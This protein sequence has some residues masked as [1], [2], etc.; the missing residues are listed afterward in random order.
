LA[1]AAA[2]LACAALSGCNVSVSS[3]GTPT[4]AKADLEKS[5][6]DKLGTGNNKPKSVTCPNDLEGA[7]G[8]AITCEVVI[9]S[10][11]AFQ[12]VLTVDKID[13]KTAE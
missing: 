8:K 11:N 1:V 3:G 13:G 6:T 12:A 2:A 9:S 4:V 7:V 10:Y 5:I